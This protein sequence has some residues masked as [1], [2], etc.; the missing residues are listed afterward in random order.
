MIRDGEWKYNHYRSGEGELY[1]L[2]DDPRELR[3][4][5]RTADHRGVVDDLREQLF[6]WYPGSAATNSGSHA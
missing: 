3:N 2:A 5:I 1:N 4:L 6:R